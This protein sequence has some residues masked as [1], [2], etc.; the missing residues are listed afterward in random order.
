[1]LL[2]NAFLFWYSWKNMQAKHEK[3]NKI[4]TLGDWLKKLN[5]PRQLFLVVLM[6]LQI[7]LD[8]KVNNRV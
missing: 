6:H 3:I 5:K 7:K 2:L 4:K 8:V 1:M